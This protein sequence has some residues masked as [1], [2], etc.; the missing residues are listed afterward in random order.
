MAD[1]SIILWLGLFMLG[2]ALV[3]L[4]AGAL[5][6][7]ELFR[8]TVKDGQPRLTRGR[9]PPALFDDLCDVLRREN[10]RSAVIRVVLEGGQP[11]LALSA[12]A[13]AAAQPLR[14]VLGR[15]SLVELRSGRMRPER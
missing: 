2:C 6:S 10:V 9:L 12:E 7:N 5:R 1:G 11:R 4:V 8:V 13:S 14:N 15:F 3:L